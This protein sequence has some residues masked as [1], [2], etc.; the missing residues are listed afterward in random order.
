[1][2]RKHRPEE[3]VTT[4]RATEFTCGCIMHPLVGYVRR[5]AALGS[6]SLSG[7]VV[8]R[9]GD[10][11]RHSKAEVIRTYPVASIIP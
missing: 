11:G 8:K 5:C 3:I 9:E 6:R 10:V 7:R 2:H 1:M 4:T